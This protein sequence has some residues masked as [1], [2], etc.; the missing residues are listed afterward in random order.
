VVNGP[1]YSSGRPGSAL[2]ILGAIFATALIVRIPLGPAP[3]EPS[4]VSIST[5]EAHPFATLSALPV[6]QMEQPA[7][8]LP[9]AMNTRSARVST[10][11]PSEPVR[12]ASAAAPIE[13]APFEAAPRSPSVL[14][15]PPVLVSE[16]LRAL[17]STPHN[18]IAELPAAAKYV[19]S[20]ESSSSNP[21]SAVGT[22]FVK[23]GAAL[24]LAFK[25]TGQGILA[26]F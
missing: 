15:Q 13:S 2:L 6:A 25:K 7:I 12:V 11:S 9:V 1:T 21:F 18:E 14:N 5:I 8:D 16:P 19:S 24:T 4:M 17:A 10:A 22:A 23:T 26:P 3:V 20:V